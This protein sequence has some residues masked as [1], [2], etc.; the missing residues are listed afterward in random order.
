MGSLLKQLVAAAIVLTIVPLPDVATASELRPGVFDH[1]DREPAPQTPEWSA[2]GQVNIG[3]L[4][5]RALCT[6]TLIA[7]QLVL[8]AAHCL[9]NARRN[10]PY[11]LDRIHFLAGVRPGNTYAGHSMA[12]CVKFPDGDWNDQPD[13]ALIV[14]KN[15]L[16]DVP[17]VEID[18]A[19]DLSVGTTLT[20]AAYPADRRFQLMVHRGCKV[21][22][23]RPGF[24]LTDCDTHEASSGGPIVVEHATGMKVVGVLAG[25]KAETAS[26]AFTLDAWPELPLTA[27]CP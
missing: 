15:P 16:A 13:I 25:V 26:V 7:P 4:R 2:I 3:G 10:A 14:L 18:Q 22:A 12:E 17:T 1:D 23:R 8:T 9:W 11:L 20:H 27:A 5:T 6:G 21:L 19:P 24:V